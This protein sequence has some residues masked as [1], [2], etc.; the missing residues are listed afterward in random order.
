MASD[1]TDNFYSYESGPNITI[2]E[3]SPDAPSI[4]DSPQSVNWNTSNANGRSI[5][6]RPETPVVPSTSFDHPQSPE[7]NG[8][9]ITK[10]FVAPTTLFPPRGQTGIGNDNHNIG[11]IRQVRRDF[12]ILPPNPVTP[13]PFY[14][15]YGSPPPAAC[16]NTLSSWG[17]CER[18]G[19]LPPLGRTP[20]SHISPTVIRG[21]DWSSGS[22]DSPLN[23]AALAGS[24]VK[25]AAPD[26]RP[27]HKSSIENV[28]LGTLDD[29]STVSL[30]PS[31][32]YCTQQ[33]RNV[34][35]QC[36]VAYRAALEHDDPADRAEAIRR[37]AAKRDWLKPQL[38]TSADLAS[39]P[40]PPK[41]VNGRATP[42][43][44]LWRRRRSF[45]KPPPLFSH[46][47]I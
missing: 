33:R 17:T 21:R 14:Y 19:N 29:D 24:P 20:N 46:F 30:V 16:G 12:P 31:E 38:P 42:A 9:V 18:Y 7:L 35:L 1:S 32:T 37:V 13:P 39:P 6:C 11:G 5:P 10:R 36:K 23:S 45:A 4:S 3:R 27:E 2:L 22:S 28:K 41:A 47:L 40:P 15:Y 25:R 34:A 44:R 43:R 8:T 26:F